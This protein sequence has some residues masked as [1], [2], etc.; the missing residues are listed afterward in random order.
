[1]RKIFVLA[2]APLCSAIAF[3]EEATIAVHVTA[4]PL[5][6]DNGGE[7]P[8]SV[9]SGPGADLRTDEE[10]QEAVRRWC[11]AVTATIAWQ[12][13]WDRFIDFYIMCQSLDNKR[14]EISQVESR[15]I[16]ASPAGHRKSNGIVKLRIPNVEGHETASVKC[17]SMYSYYPGLY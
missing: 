15:R 6:V 5:I 3:A 17:Y 10:I 4:R 13:T 7:C 8:A 16:V 2:A 12:N 1:M 9:H 14:R 11:D